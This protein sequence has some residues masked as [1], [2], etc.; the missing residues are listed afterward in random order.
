MTTS[1]R[2]PSGSMAPPRLQSRATS[3]SSL[4]EDG[5]ETTVAV[6]LGDD[7]AEIGELAAG[8]A[9]LCLLHRVCRGR[10]SA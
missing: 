9:A 3:R 8:V 4:R 6:V 2:R 5:A 1:W 10:A 7:D